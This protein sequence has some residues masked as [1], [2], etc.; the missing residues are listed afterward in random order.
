VTLEKGILAY[1]IVAFAEWAK[2][3][4]DENT[5]QRLLSGDF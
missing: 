5:L 1:W 4:R 2:G 3:N